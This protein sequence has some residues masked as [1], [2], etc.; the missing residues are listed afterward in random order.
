MKESMNVEEPTIDLSKPVWLFGFYKMESLS[1]A[2]ATL[3]YVQDFYWVRDAKPY[4]ILKGDEKVSLLP[5]YL[6]DEICIVY[7]DPTGK[8]RKYHGVVT[9]IRAAVSAFKAGWRA[10]K[11]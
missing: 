1:L 6:R 5:D 3:D 10:A 4:M 7:D 2:K 9:E 8:F 11:E